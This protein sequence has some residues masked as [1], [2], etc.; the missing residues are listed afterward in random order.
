[1]EEISSII[2]SIFPIHRASFALSDCIK[3]FNLLAPYINSP[4][5]YADLL[6]FKF[7]LGVLEIS[8]IISY[9]NTRGLY[10]V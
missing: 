10:G 6:D 5:A 4:N 2:Y 8:E 3:T 7:P 1:M 9:V